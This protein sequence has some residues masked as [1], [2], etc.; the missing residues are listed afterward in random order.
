MKLLDFVILLPIAFWALYA[1]RAVR[2]SKAHCGGC[3]GDCAHC[4][5]ACGQS[6]KAPH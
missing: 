1:L 2:R 3:S 5:A 4:G 6:Q